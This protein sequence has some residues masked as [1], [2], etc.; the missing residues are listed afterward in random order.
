MLMVRKKKLL[1]NRSEAK[2][3]Q[4]RDDL[5]PDMNQMIQNFMPFSH[6]MAFSV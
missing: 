3:K 5:I 1:N 6:L 2:L 4:V